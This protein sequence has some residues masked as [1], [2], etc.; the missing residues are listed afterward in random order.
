MDRKHRAPK[1]AL[2]RGENH[3]YTLRVVVNG[4]KAPSAKRCI[5]TGEFRRDQ[6]LRCRVRK[7]R[8]PNGALR[9]LRGVHCEGC[10]P[11][12]KAPST[13][14]CI[15]TPTNHETAPQS[16]ASQKAPSAKR[17]IKTDDPPPMRTQ[18]HAQSESTKRPIRYI[19]TNQIDPLLNCWMRVRKHRAPKGTLRLHEVLVLVEVEIKFRKHRAP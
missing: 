9:R 5:K 18:S 16:P 6:S 1:G 13:K 10:V 8:A 15:T 14:R 4:Q 7:H 3:R 12:Q 11:G 2:R 17:R 19:M